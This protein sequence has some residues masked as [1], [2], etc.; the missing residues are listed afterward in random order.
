MSEEMKKVDFV[1]DRSFLGHPKGLGTTTSMQAMHAFSHYGMSAILVYYLYESV[2]NAGL[3]FDQ[4][5][6]AQLTSYYISMFPIAGVVGAYV[7]E[8]FIGVRKAL[9]LGWILR[10]IALLFLAIPGGGIAF[11]VANQCLLLVSASCLGQSLYAL[12]G[13]MYSKTEPRRDGAFTLMYVMNNVGTISPMITGLP[14]RY[15]CRGHVS[16][17]CDNYHMTLFARIHDLSD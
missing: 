17:K 8:R 13:K 11:Y 12:V 16:C 5:L 14:P 3:R 10:V 15:Y 9:I 2:Q 1:N 6:A 4:G 7:A